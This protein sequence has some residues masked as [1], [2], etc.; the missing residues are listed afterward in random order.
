MRVKT[1]N[2]GAGDTRGQIIRMVR[3]LQGKNTNLPESFRSLINGDD[4]VAKI[5]AMAKEASKKVGGLG[6]K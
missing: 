3:T 5:R 6:R 2:Q 4:L 1:P